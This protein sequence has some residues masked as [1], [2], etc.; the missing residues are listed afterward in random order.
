MVP[1][2][3]GG[4]TPTTKN[5]IKLRDPRLGAG[6]NDGHN[7]GSTPRGRYDRAFSPEDYP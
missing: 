3:T 1:A 6:T 4:H 5:H 7:V 2:R